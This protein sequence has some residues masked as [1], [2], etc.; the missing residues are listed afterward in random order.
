MVTVRRFMEVTMTEAGQHIKT[1]GELRAAIEES[2]AVFIYPIFF[3]KN[4]G[5]AEVQISKADARMVVAADN[6]KRHP[7]EWGAKDLNS[8]MDEGE[9]IAFLAANGN[10]YINLV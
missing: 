6:K 1:M 7:D 5:G 9:D 4:D 3:G 10:L 8:D 2:V